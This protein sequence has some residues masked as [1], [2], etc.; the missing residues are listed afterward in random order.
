LAALL[1][2]YLR[3]A[4]SI[5]ET[6]NG[7][8]SNNQNIKTIKTTMK[9]ISLFLSIISLLFVACQNEP[10]DTSNP[11]ADSLARENAKMQE[12]IKGKEESIQDFIVA[13]NEI[14]DNLDV[15][16]SK[17]GVIKSVGKNNEK[18]KI[19]K[20]QIIEDIQSINELMEKNKNRLASLKGKLSKSDAKVGELEKFINY[21][22]DQLAAQV[23]EIDQ[24]KMDLEKMNMRM[25]DLNQKYQ[26]SVAE[27]NQKTSQLNTAWYAVGT[28][29][30]LLSKGVITKEG[31][32]I[33]IGKSKKLADNMNKEYFTKIDITEKKSIPIGARKA[34]L[35]STH[36]ASSYTIAGS[37]NAEKLIINNVE[38]FWAASKYLVILIEKQ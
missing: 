4:D 19:S 18:V 15:I 34:K 28:T 22:N 10:V 20:D 7:L 8:I 26:T 11:L 21:L 38:E 12:V 5:A 9:K 17:Q 30:E 3:W 35:L 27:S 1:A 37:G 32:I 31:G 33:G 23:V 14:Q 2:L 16:K 25:A 13:F 36:P 29:K 24:L 6:C